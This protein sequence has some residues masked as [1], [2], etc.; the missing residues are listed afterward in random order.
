[1]F[2]LFLQP[3]NRKA[4]VRC[5]SRLPFEVHGGYGTRGHFGACRWISSSDGGKAEENAKPLDEDKDWIPPDRPLIGDQGQA[6]LYK[7]AEKLQETEKALEEA[8][9]TISDEDSQEDILRKL[10]EA[11]TIEQQLLVEG[12]EELSSEEQQPDWLQTRRAAL[13]K[14]SATDVIPVLQHT[15]LTEEE[16][17]KFLEFLGG[18]D[19]KVL[20]TINGRLG[21]GVDAMVLCTASSAFQI[22]TISQALVEHLKERNLHELGVSGADQMSKKS[23]SANNP[24]S[25]SNWNAIDCQ[26]YI[27]HILDEHTRRALNLEALWSGTDPLLKLNLGNE[28]AE[29]EYVADHPVPADY[30][31]SPEQL[32]GVDISK[33]QRNQFTIEHKPVV[34]FSQKFQDRKDGRKRRRLQR[35]QQKSERY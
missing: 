27:V 32:W 35:Q 31:P 17:L 4:L 21:E 13:G 28:D 29:D 5:S 23:S 25:S 19:M 12:E 9:F 33:L 22:R 24:M 34:P 20:S 8:L 11:L 26:N 2:R 1:M 3:S 6:H 10:E 18:K 7:Q 15:L 16:L 14:H 30:G